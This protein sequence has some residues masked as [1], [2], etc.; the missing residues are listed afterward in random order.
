VILVLISVPFQGEILWPKSQACAPAAETNT[1][2]QA[3]TV[4][5]KGATCPL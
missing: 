4:T 1:V 3:E 5:A 2:D